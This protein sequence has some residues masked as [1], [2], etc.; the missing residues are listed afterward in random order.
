LPLQE[1]KRLLKLLSL[2]FSST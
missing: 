1:K 2:Y